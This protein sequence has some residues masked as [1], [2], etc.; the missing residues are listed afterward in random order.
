VEPGEHGGPSLQQE[1]GRGK[2][3]RGVGSLTRRH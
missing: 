3:E 2:G 1:R